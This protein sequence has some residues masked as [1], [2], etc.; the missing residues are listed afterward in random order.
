MFTDMPIWRS[1]EDEAGEISGAADIEYDLEGSWTVESISVRTTN[2]RTGRTYSR[3]VDW[4][5]PLWCLIERALT[6]TQSTEIEHRVSIAVASITPWPSL[7]RINA[8]NR[9]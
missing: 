4:D 5:D 1:F 8:E 2:R 9:T 6:T 7:A 3:R